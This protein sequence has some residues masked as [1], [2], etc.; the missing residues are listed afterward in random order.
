VTG[1]L[2][3][4]LLKI[5]TTRLWWTMLV[6]VLVLGAAY[7]VLPAAIALLS[8]EAAGTTEPFADPG[9]LRSV[10]NG[11]NTLT[12]ILA[13]VVGI[14]SLGTVYRHRTLAGTY[15]ATPHRYRLLAAKSAALLVLGLCYGVASVLAGVLVAVPF[16]LTQ[17]GSFF[18][19][20]GDVWRSLVL[21]VL[22]IALWT[23]IGM[24]V[25]IL[26]RNIV[27]AMLLGIGF[28]YL[29]EPTLSVLFLFRGWDL[30]L[31]LMPSGATNAMLGVTSPVLLATSQPLTWWQGALV[32][33]G[34][35]V[36]PAVAGALLTISRDVD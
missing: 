32:L 13:L 22:A 18:L 30:P 2:R 25:G 14:M 21:G 17:H 10:Y 27:L 12:R 33:T 1:A 34:W 8:S 6:C 7:A 28:S 16:V 15:L 36:L 20:R 24:G 35:C 29:V 23:L 9:T 3:A 31:N 11:G 19:D 26:G 5:T 4:E